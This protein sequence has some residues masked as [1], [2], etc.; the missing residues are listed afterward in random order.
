[1]VAR[2][3]VALV[4]AVLGHQSGVIGD[5]TYAAGAVVTLLT[6]LVAPLLLRL[7]LPRRQAID[8]NGITEDSHRSEIAAQIERL[9]I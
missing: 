9:E 1:M 4:I 2:G 5:E 6:T 3:E 8:A 7:A